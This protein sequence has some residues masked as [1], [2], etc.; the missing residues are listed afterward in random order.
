MAALMSPKALQGR[1][2]D[3]VSVRRS[4]PSS[5][6]SQTG[7]PDR[8]LGDPQGGAPREVKPVPRLRKAHSSPVAKTDVARIRDRPRIK[9]ADL[10]NPTGY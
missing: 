4:T 5:V 6:G 8:K 7:R 10:R 9:R 3:A 2:T 1:P